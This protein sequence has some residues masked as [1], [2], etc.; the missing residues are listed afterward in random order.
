MTANAAALALADLHRDHEKRF[1]QAG[2][3]I[4]ALAALA[5]ELL[6]ELHDWAFTH[7]LPPHTAAA[8]IRTHYGHNIAEDYHADHDTEAA[9]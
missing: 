1:T 3:S 4:T 2:D 7:N 9:A 6:D 8:M 5:G